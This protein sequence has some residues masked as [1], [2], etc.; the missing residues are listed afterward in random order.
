MPPCAQISDS[1]QFVIS[2][3][4]VKTILVNQ[5]VK[6]REFSK[7]RSTRPTV[8]KRYIFQIFERLTSHLLGAF[9]LLSQKIKVIELID[10]NCTELTLFTTHSLIA[11][12]R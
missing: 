5:N 6:Q 10:V 1:R 4:N 2:V 7:W 12:Y 11:T 3:F 9:V 8:N